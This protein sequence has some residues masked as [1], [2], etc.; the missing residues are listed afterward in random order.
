MLEFIERAIAKIKKIKI[1]L[2]V[3]LFRLEVPKYFYLG[4]SEN[5][6]VVLYATFEVRNVG[7]RVMSFYQANKKP[8]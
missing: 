2:I 8:L 7:F 6:S 4:I 5:N 1:F 3:S